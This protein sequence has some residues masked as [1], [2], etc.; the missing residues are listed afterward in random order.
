M[1]LNQYLAKY[2]PLSRRGADS[3]VSEGRVEINGTLAKLGDV[4]IESDRVSLDGQ[5]VT[6]DIALQTILI[7]KPVN[8]V[9]S[10]NGQGS[11]TVYD[12]LPLHLRHLNSVGRLDKDS[13]GLLVMTNDGN[14]AHQLTHPRYKKTKIYHVTLD[15]P[16]TPQQQH[17]ISTDGI[18][19]ADGLS[20]I[21]LSPLDQNRKSWHIT[22]HEGRNRQIR[23]TFAATHHTVL[24]LHR[25]SFG[26]YKLG[27]LA[28]G[29]FQQVTPLDLEK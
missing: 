12:L 11:K 16:L 10:K 22:M 27:D 29:Q 3:A 8:Y 26:A 13:S 5:L 21:T 7:H 9:C 25:I 17:M 23:R 6:A 18:Q 14:L 1:R 24:S 2:T 4:V 15:S 28:L 19:L 20:R